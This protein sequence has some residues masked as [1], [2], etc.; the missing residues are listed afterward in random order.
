M[1]GHKF[2]AKEMI[3]SGE[4]NFKKMVTILMQ[5]L[6]ILWIS[7]KGVLLLQ[8]W[9]TLSIEKGFKVR[10]PKF[11]VCGKFLR[12][13]VRHEKATGWSIWI[14]GMVHSLKGI[15]QGSSLQFF[16]SNFESNA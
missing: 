15:G 6:G 16:A 2:E 5:I 8:I 11:D 13:E 7:A 12:R 1:L 3:S 14:R 10:W 4:K 9:H